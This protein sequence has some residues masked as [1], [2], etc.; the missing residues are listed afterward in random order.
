MKIMNTN[1]YTTSQF[2]PIDSD[3]KVGN[4]RIIVISLN[5]L[6]FFVNKIMSHRL[7]YVDDFTS[8][9]SLHPVITNRHSE[10]KQLHHTTSNLSFHIC[11]HF[12]M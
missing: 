3:N 9:G 4:Q 2:S 12:G 1:M 6:L 8:P 7:H 10:H 5:S 11:K